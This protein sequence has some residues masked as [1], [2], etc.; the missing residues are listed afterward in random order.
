MV[1]YTVFS[2]N[3]TLKNFIFYSFVMQTT[4]KPFCLASLSRENKIRL[5]CEEKKLLHVVMREI[6]LER[7]HISS[8]HLGLRQVQRDVCCVNNINILPLWPH[9]F[10]ITPVLKKLYFYLFL[11]VCFFQD[12]ANLVFRCFCSRFHRC[13]VMSSESARAVWYQIII[14]LLWNIFGY[15]IIALASHI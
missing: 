5:L 4:R 1:L 6:Y 7:Q 3:F 13:Q 14:Y 2:K 9:K 15:Q 10:V 8:I 12:L 11:T